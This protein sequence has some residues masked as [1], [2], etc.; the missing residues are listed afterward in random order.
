MDEDEPNDPDL[1]GAEDEAIE[2]DLMDDPAE[3]EDADQGAEKTSIFVKLRRN[4]REE[5]EDEFDDLEDDLFEDDLKDMEAEETQPEIE[6][7]EEAP[8]VKRETAGKAASED[9]LQAQ[10]NKKRQTAPQEP[11]YSDIKG[12]E[13]FQSKENTRYKGADLDA[14]LDI[15]DLNDL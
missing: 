3:D 8:E 13:A 12:T 10:P 6:T 5:E 7:T 9:A 14:Q 11:I 1:A 2:E 4:L 15:L